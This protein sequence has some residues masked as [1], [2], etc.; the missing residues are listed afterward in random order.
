MAVWILKVV[1]VSCYRANDWFNTQWVSLSSV[2][3]L[4]TQSRMCTKSL[5]KY[6]MR[7]FVFDL[8]FWRWRPECF[9]IILLW[10]IWNEH[11]DLFVHVDRFK[12]FMPLLENVCAFFWA[13]VSFVYRC[14]SMCIV[15]EWVG[16]DIMLIP[17][18]IFVPWV[19]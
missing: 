2:K 17:Q 9:H 1:E 12:W 19:W 11:T 18:L 16:S 15:L 5:I 7:L 4:K 10:S 14:L 8:S 3:L 6:F 13:R